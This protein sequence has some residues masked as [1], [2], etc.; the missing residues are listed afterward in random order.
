MSRVP[1]F[2]PSALGCEQAAD[3][4]IAGLDG[5]LDGDE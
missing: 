3:Q 2:S 4:V 1:S 5:V